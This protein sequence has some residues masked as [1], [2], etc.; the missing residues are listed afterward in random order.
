MSV[1]FRA[2]AE[3]EFVSLPASTAEEEYENYG[4]HGF[5]SYTSLLTGRNTNV[6]AELVARIEAASTD[7]EKTK[8]FDRDM[9]DLPEQMQLKHTAET[10]IPKL[11]NPPRENRK[12][13]EFILNIESY[14]YK[15]HLLEKSRLLISHL[16]HRAG[17]LFLQKTDHY[18]RI[19]KLDLST[20]GKLE[21]T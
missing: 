17:K 2:F 19:F 15:Y 18:L 11:K 1:S 16:S 6:T 4:S 9:L 20:V 21:Y 8:I 14:R 7:D 5:V 10:L 3:E 13:Y 12:K